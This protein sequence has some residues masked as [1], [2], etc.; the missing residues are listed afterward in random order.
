MKLDQ[1]AYFV[2][3]AR[4]EHLA[5]AA[6]TL[7]ISPSAVSHAIAKLE[8]ELGQ[9]LFERDGKRIHLTTR[10]RQL[11]EQAAEVLAS[12]ERLR[13][14]FTAGAEHV[15]HFRVAA[16]HGLASHWVAP[17]WT[18]IAAENPKLSVELFSMRTAEVL[19]TVGAREVDIGF[20][21]NAVAP[22]GVASTIVYRSR[23][24]VAVR[25]N[26]PI[27]ERPSNQR[28]KAL[29]S[30]PSAAPKS[31]S[32]VEDCESH[33]LLQRWGIT[34]RVPFI[35]DNYVVAESILQT[36]EAWALIPEWVA[37]RSRALTIAVAPEPSAAALTVHALWSKSRP[38]A[39]ALRELVARVEARGTLP[40]PGAVLTASN[41]P[42]PSR[43]S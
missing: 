28:P 40:E 25:K 8:A 36:T 29:A 19:R 43:G 9:A 17:S 33:P 2:E 30:F 7:S 21:Y 3:V 41:R 37:A 23:L 10:G 6:R 11:A 5:K 38:P 22:N 24:V 34:P 15:G 39:R 20:G 14:D 27:L 31:F 4:H 35:F 16:T 1:L 18:A 26:H 13:E 12:V 32:G 42:A